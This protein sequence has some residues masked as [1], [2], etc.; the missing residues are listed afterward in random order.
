MLDRFDVGR[1]FARAASGAAPC[2]DGVDRPAGLREMCCD[3]LGLAI[4]GIGHGTQDGIGNLGMEPP[5]LAPQ[6]R[7]VDF[8]AQQGMMEP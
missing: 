3:H 5:A 6:R 7:L 4:Q 2:G 1:P 8:I